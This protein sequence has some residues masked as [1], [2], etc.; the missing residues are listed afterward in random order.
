MNTT[1]TENKYYLLATTIFQ[2]N[3]LKYI[4]I[5]A[6]SATPEEVKGLK[7]MSSVAKYKGLKKFKPINLHA[8]PNR[9]SSASPRPTES[10]YKTEH[11]NNMLRT[12]EAWH[13]LNYKKLSQLNYALLLKKEVVL[14]L[15]RWISLKDNQKYQDLMLSCLKGVYSVYKTYCESLTT[16]NQ[17]NFGIKYEL[18]N[19]KPALSS[20]QPRVAAKT[21]IGD[22]R[23]QSFTKLDTTAA[24][25]FNNTFFEPSYYQ[26]RMKKIMRGSKDIIKWVYDRNGTSYKDNFV[27]K[28]FSKS[29]KIS[30]AL[31]SSTV[32]KLLP[33][34]L[35]N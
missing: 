24:N 10:F 33:S 25:K 29:Q 34:S 6:N 32:I 16:T 11:C 8:V 19:I 14:Y 5:W 7:V 13:I 23:K 21:P 12:S 17:A 18:K 3:Y 15:E 20:N 28:K 9:D 35:P 26:N 31:D 2:E 4:S 22:N 1:L 30:K 27:N